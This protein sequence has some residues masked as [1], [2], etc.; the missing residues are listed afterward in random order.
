MAITH[1]K[2]MTKGTYWKVI[3]LFIPTAVSQ[4]ILPILSSLVKTDKTKYW[5]VLKINILV[6][7]F[8]ALAMVGLVICF[9]QYIMAAYGSNFENTMPLMILAISTVFT[10]VGNVVGLA[11]ASKSQMWLGF[12]FNIVWGIVLVVS[13]YYLIEKGYG[14]VGVALSILLAYVIHSFI[15]IIYL[16]RLRAIEN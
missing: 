5:K 16:K 11:I 2:D 8:V 15:Q 7:A 9:S 13:A 3:I 4:I 1:T 12:L 6:N 10:A 14:S